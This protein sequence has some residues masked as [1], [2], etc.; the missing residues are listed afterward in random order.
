MAGFFFLPN[1]VTQYNYFPGIFLPGLLLLPKT[2]YFLRKNPLWIAILIYLG[3]MLCTSF[4]SYEFSFSTFLYDSKLAL[5]ILVFLMTTVA[6]DLTDKFRRIYKRIGE[7]YRCARYIPLRQLGRRVYLTLKRGIVCRL[8]C[9][10][11][12]PRRRPAYR[13]SPWPSSPLRMDTIRERQ[14]GM[15]LHYQKL[16]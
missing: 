4:W 13:A 2:E 8:P 9:V 16:S 15:E 6:I 3:Y 7:T 12:V 5:Y 10:L 14:K 1:A 11:S